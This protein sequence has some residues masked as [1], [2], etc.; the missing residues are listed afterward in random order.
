MLE[1]P[2]HEH[3]KCRKLHW[4]RQELLGPLLD[5]ADGQVDGAMGGQDHHGDRGIDGFEGLQELEA[6]SVREAV[7]HDRGVG[8][9][10]VED[11]PGPRDAVGPHDLIAIVREEPPDRGPDPLFVLDYDQPVLGHRWSL[12]RG[13]VASSCSQL[14]RPSLSLDTRLGHDGSSSKARR[15]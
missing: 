9:R 3:K 2:L 10:H 6:V 13:L 14:T 4:L 8:T 11:L 1:S 5:G 15:K 7:V 12:A